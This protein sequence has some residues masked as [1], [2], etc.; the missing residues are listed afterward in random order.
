MD[1]QTFIQEQRTPKQFLEVY[2]QFE[3]LIHFGKEE[4][5]TAKK[6]LRIYEHMME[7][8]KSDYNLLTAFTKD[9]ESFRGIFLFCVCVSSFENIGMTE[10]QAYFLIC[11]DY[12]P[13]CLHF[14]IKEWKDHVIDH[15]K[16]SSKHLALLLFLAT[17]K[18]SQ[19]TTFGFICQYVNT[20][21]MQSFYAK[22][23]KLKCSLLIQLC[24][25]ANIVIIL[26]T[27]LVFV[28]VHVV[29]KLIKQT[30]F[31]YAYW[32][33]CWKAL[34]ENLVEKPVF[35]QHKNDE[36]ELKKYLY[37][38]RKNAHDKIVLHPDLVFAW[39]ILLGQQKT[40]TD[41][42]AKIC[43]HI[44]I[45]PNDVDVVLPKLSQCEIEEIMNLAKSQHRERIECE[46]EK[47][48]ALKFQELT[49]QENDSIQG[50]QE[51]KKYKEIL[52]KQYKIEN[53]QKKKLE[54][55]QQSQ[56]LQQQ[57]QI[58][59]KWS[60]QTRESVQER[61]NIFK[62]IQKW[63]KQAKNCLNA[64]KL[65]SLNR[66]VVH[67]CLQLVS[68][69][70]AHMQSLDNKK[71]WPSS[72]ANCLTNLRFIAVSHEAF[73]ESSCKIERFEEACANILSSTIVKDVNKLFRD[74]LFHSF[75]SLR[76]ILQLLIQSVDLFQTFVVACPSIF[77]A[78][79]SVIY[80]N[81]LDSSMDHM[82]QLEKKF[83][84]YNLRNILTAPLTKIC[85]NWLQRK[86]RT[87][88]C[89]MLGLGIKK[90]K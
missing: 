12:F 49:R 37:F 17:A 84:V 41:P 24:T 69:C 3:K 5:W 14:I 9:F 60:L 71:V 80:A 22:I 66:F 15:K 33:N 13:Q 77:K 81:E 21:P 31:K 58:V 18:I 67:V 19:Q 76:F 29:A 51:S 27:K 54:K 53:K 44:E 89:D 1:C 46:I 34:I 72:V 35:F 70:F 82:T 57:R 65:M 78:N 47:K 75:S 45:Q 74:K 38:L 28:D 16:D 85:L 90:L 25:L 56:I 55:H 68:L 4:T 52:K 10:L 61:E 73:H 64:G 83:N 40:L 23:Q 86:S 42:R 87:N 30:D 26:T 39:A 62:A 48:Q 20:L 6:L 43:A 36:I 88:L 2:P 50:A 63:K 8:V 11:A 79:L 7:F 32:D 59:E